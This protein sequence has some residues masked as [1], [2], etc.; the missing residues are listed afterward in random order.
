MVHFHLGNALH[1]LGR[2]TESIAEYRESVRI[3]PDVPEVHYELAYALAQIPGQLAEAVA[4]CQK[5]LSLRPGDGP[6]LRLMASLL[7]FR[8]GNKR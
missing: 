3:D 2:L 4:E 7:A 1:R 8:N 5:M 6:G